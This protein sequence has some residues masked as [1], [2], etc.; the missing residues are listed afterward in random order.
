MSTTRTTTIGLIS[1]HLA[2]IALSNYLVTLPF[3]VMGFKLTW[4]AFSFPLIVVATDLTVR[5]IGKSEAR[6][7]VALAYLPA[8]LVT[9]A[10]VMATGAPD[11]VAYRIGLASATAYLF[12]NLMDVYVF[13]K[14]RERMSAWYWAPLLSSILANFLDTFVFF[15]VAFYQSADP[16]MAANWM[17][18]AANQSWVKIIISAAV[19]LPTYGVLLS[20]LSRKLG[21]D[22]TAPTTR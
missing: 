9:I 19:I 16:F 22:L 5:L 13:Q 2:I 7:V 4:A 18:V 14:V 17:N 12:S 8:I 10:V 6:K 21:S 20:Y 1:F 15:G 11:S 3:M